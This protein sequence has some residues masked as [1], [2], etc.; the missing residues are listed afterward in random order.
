M[1]RAGGTLSWWRRR[2]GTAL[3]VL[4][5][6]AGAP[7]AVSG[8]ETERSDA[9]PTKEDPFPGAISAEDLE[10]LRSLDILHDW[11]LLRDWDPEENLPIPVSAPRPP[12]P[13]GNDP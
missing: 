9:A 4:T 8:A 3:A 13:E 5:F 2:G 7:G 6:A 10:L 1:E 11:E 12:P